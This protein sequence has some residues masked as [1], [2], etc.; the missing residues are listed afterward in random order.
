MLKRNE[1]QL[2][3]MYVRFKQRMRPQTGAWIGWQDRI[4]TQKRFEMSWAP[5]WHQKGQQQLP[6]SH[7]KTPPQTPPKSPCHPG[8]IN[9]LIRQIGVRN[10][11]Q[12]VCCVLSS[13]CV[14]TVCPNLTPQAESQSLAQRQPAKGLRLR[15]DN[16]NM[17]LMNPHEQFRSEMRHVVDQ[18]LIKMDQTTWLSGQAFQAFK[19]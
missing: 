6:T 9:P 14:S 13:M 8:P 5:N 11:K 2:H 3:Y 4:Q 12:T 17:Y 10:L 1:I 18:K 7:V 15:L 19:V 16:Q